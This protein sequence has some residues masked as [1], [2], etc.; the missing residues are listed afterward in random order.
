MKAL[1]LISTHCMKIQDSGF[2]KKLDS[3]NEKA[4]NK[5]NFLSL[6]IDPI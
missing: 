3:A 1:S 5:K 4:I 2:H 6:S